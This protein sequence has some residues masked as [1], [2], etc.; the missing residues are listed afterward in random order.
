MRTCFFSVAL[1]STSAGF[2]LP[3]AFRSAE[4]LLDPQIPDGE[5]TDLSLPSPPG[6]PD[7]SRRVG[8]HAQLRQDVEVF[9]N[10]LEP[11]ATSYPLS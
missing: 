2:S 9:G 6:D 1:V 11:R 3:N 5:V 4:A 8:V 7:C 10:A